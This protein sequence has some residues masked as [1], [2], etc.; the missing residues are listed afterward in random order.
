MGQW[1]GGTALSK[2]QQR[3]AADPSLSQEQRRALEI[4]CELADL[5]VQHVGGLTAR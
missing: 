3:A 2:Y 5:D 1:D 4:A